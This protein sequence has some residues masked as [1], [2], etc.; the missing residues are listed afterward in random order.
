VEQSVV[1]DFQ[2]ILYSINIYFFVGI[3]EGL[4]TKNEVNEG[5][6]SLVSLFLPMVC[7]N[8]CF[9]FDLEISFI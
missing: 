6:N 3:V 2:Q 4:F 8:V 1:R 5:K 7:S 9:V